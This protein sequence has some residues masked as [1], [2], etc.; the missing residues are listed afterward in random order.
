V[1]PRP[2]ISIAAGLLALTSCGGISS[3][4]LQKLQS[5]DQNATNA[6]GHLEQC[7]GAALQVNV[8]DCL[9]RNVL[10]AHDAGLAEGAATCP[11]ET[12]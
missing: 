11:K 6:Q 7:P 5:A 1:T 2:R 12:P 9:V 4:E 10:S 3:T 8:S